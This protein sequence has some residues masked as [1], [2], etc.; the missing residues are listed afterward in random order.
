MLVKVKEDLKHSDARYKWA[1]RT[2]LVV[3]IFTSCKA[4]QFDTGEIVKFYHQHL[5][6]VNRR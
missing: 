4:V 6:P 5:E 3:N 1:G 2:G